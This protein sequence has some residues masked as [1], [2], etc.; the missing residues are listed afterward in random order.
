MGLAAFDL[1]CFAV[2]QI[3][4]KQ[5]RFGFH[6]KV[7]PVAFGCGHQNGPV[8]VVVPQRGRDLE[9]ARKL[10]I[11]LHRIVVFQLLGKLL[12]HIGL[13]HHMVIDG[14]IANGQHVFQVAAQLFRFKQLLSKELVVAQALVF[15]AVHQDVTL[16]TID[17]IRCNFNELLRV[18]F[19]VI[20][21]AAL[22]ENPNNRLA[23]QLCSVLQLGKQVRQFDVGL[24]QGDDV[25]PGFFR[26][27]HACLPNG[28]VGLTPLQPGLGDSWGILQCLDAIRNQLFIVELYA[29][30]RL[31]L[32]AVP[33][34]FEL[35]A[36]Q[37]TLANGECVRL[38]SAFLISSLPES[39][40]STAT[41]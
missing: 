16:A 36:D 30:G 23:G 26:G 40:L 9:P 35:W 27:F 18:A 2:S 37:H 10:G 39:F 8:R 15:D 5:A 19:E 28:H 38:S 3:A 24:M 31:V 29:V 4:G 20:E 34:G 7:Q 13:P 14:L 11:D 12:L 41:I 25:G 33:K 17:R 22:G 32:D 1:V 21:A 6:H